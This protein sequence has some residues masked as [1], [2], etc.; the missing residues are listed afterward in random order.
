MCTG[1]GDLSPESQELTSW[2]GCQATWSMSLLKRNKENKKWCWLLLTVPTN[3]NPVGKTIWAPLMVHL[4]LQC[5]IELVRRSNLA[6]SQQPTHPCLPH[7][8][9]LVRQSKFYSTLLQRNI[10]SAE[11]DKCAPRVQINVSPHGALSSLFISSSSVWPSSWEI[12]LKFNICKWRLK[13]KS[14]YWGRWKRL[15]SWVTLL[16]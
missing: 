16:L 12:E 10:D 8:Q 5:L 13:N 1:E 15:S 4:S 3:L 9:E 14:S 11:R 6:Y 2:S 7:Y